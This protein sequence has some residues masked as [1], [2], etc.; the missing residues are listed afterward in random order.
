MSLKMIVVFL[1]M[2][3]LFLP[4]T[5]ASPP[6]VSCVGCDGKTSEIVT[7]GIN[8]W[9]TFYAKEGSP[10]T[11]RGSSGFWQDE[12]GQA[13][14]D[15]SSWSFTAKDNAMYIL[16]SPSG[17]FYA[18]VNI[19]PLSS[20]LPE[21]ISDI[22]VNG[23]EI[24]N[25]G[26]IETAQ[27]NSLK[28][29]LVVTK[30]DC[31]VYHIEWTSDSPVITFSDFDSLSTIAYVGGYSGK[32]PTITATIYSENRERQKIRDIG[33]EIH[34]NTPP[35]INIDWEPD[36]VEVE[37]YERFTVYF[38]GSTTGRSGDEDGDYIAVVEA[39]L[40]DA[41]GK[42][43]SHSRRTMDRQ[44]PLPIL[45]LTSRSVGQYTLAVQITDRYGATDTADVTILVTEKGDSGRDKPVVDSPD[46]INCVAGEV[47]DLSINADGD[48]FIEYLY[49]GKR[50][51]KPFKFP[52]GDHEVII[53]AYYLDENGRQRNV[54]TKPVWVHVV[55]NA[56]AIP[57]PANAAPIA[58]EDLA[59]TSPLG[60]ASAVIVAWRI[61]H[62]RRILKS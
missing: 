13:I 62:R 27:G 23:D 42:L 59:E 8:A 28:L 60:G 32:N 24:E 36:S 2:L 15:G 5:L 47:C 26:K 20:E 54:V 30:G 49:Q 22:Y 18:T 56:S 57:E 25:H 38:E 19:I 11:L 3:S 10:I 41:S 14:G 46:D 53:R 43:V 1:V 9:Q 58:R 50:M 52:P 48:T 35:A 29:K 16:K 34:K 61:L 6:A 40:R 7:N 44:M 21:T 31:S 12:A 45:S 51:I 39:W 55:A 4:I 17:D 37:S 33:L